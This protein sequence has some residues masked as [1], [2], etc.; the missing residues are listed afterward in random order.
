M[1][2]GFS[3]KG[4]GDF[5]CELML[6]SWKG[7]VEVV[8]RNKMVIKMVNRLLVVHLE[9][10]ETDVDINPFYYEKHLKKFVIKF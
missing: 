6:I 4:Q 3:R 1:E 5:Q 9:I 10:F 2:G 8:G 7:H